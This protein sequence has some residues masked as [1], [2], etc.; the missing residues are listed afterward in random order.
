MVIVGASKIHLPNPQNSQ[1]LPTM[2][3]PQNANAGTVVSVIINP[4]L[5]LVDSDS[6]ADL[7]QMQQE[8][9]AEQRRIEEVTQAKLAVAHER[10][11]KKQKAKEE[12]AW[13]AEEVQKA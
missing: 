3:S 12:E 9:M 13:K 11:E 8:A 1:L 7:E 6:E 2:T 10:M 5:I 4:E